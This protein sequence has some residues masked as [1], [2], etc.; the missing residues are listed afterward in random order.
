[1]K[2]YYEI[3]G[4]WLKVSPLFPMAPPT[5]PHCGHKLARLETES[6]RATWQYDEGYKWHWY[7]EQQAYWFFCLP[8]HNEVWPD[9]FRPAHNKCQG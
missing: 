5:C 1:M 6:L 9:D 4:P 8:C 3:H 7:T 2:G